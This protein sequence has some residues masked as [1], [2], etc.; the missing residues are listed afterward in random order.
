MTAASTSASRR[1]VSASAIRSVAMA[2]HRRIVIGSQSVG[3]EI[4][5]SD[6]MTWP[7][8][9]H[10]LSAMPNLAHLLTDSAAAHPDHVAIGLDALALTYRELDA[11]TARVAG[12][13]GPRASRPATAS[14]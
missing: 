6:P 10:S 1:A 9:G 14:R 2:G 3:G 11:A 12:L 7:W 8:R 4:R 5:V 13:L